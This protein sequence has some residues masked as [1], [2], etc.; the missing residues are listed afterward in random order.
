MMDVFL[1]CTAKNQYKKLNEP[2]LSRITVAIDGLEKEPP[3]GDIKELAGKT[4]VFRL[5]VGSYRILY[6]VGEGFIDVFKIAP[7]GQVY[8]E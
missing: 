2:M 1:T 4:G 8:K 7:R 3:I 5:R 6:T